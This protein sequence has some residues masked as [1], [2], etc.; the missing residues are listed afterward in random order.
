LERNKLIN[1]ERN[2]QVLDEFGKILIETAFDGQMSLTKNSL[3]DL[4]NT[5][6]FQNLFQTMNETQKKE[7]EA[8]SFEILSGL[9][10]D[11]LK[12]FEENEEFKIM[13]VEDS[14]YIDLSKISENLKAEP[15]IENGWIERFSRVLGNDMGD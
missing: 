8:L 11:F 7:L 15:I 4:R 14:N 1:M 12:L 9:L 2:K 5:K 3:E 13:Y 10:F 6:R